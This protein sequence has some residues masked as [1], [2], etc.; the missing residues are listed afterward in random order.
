MSPWNVIER[1]PRSRGVT[2]LMY[3]GD[4]EAVEKAVGH[5]RP[6][7]SLLATIS[8]GVAIFGP[9]KYRKAAVIVGAASW[10][11]I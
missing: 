2:Q 11:A 10:L 7:A 1:R 9:K 3:V 8:F 6:I 4:D 5:G